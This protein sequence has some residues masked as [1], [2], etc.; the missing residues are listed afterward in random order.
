MSDLAEKIARYER[1]LNEVWSSSVKYL[2]LFSVQL[3]MERVVFDVA[4]EY[5]EIELVKW[6]EKGISCEEVAQVLQEEP[7]FPVDDMFMKFITKYVEVLAKL[8]GSEKAER[9]M[10]KIKEETIKEE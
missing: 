1:F 5:R 7:N 4:T 9:I 8:I 3:L 2:G 10:E 6:D